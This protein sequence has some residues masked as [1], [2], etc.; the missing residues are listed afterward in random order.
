[1]SSVFLV[2]ITDLDVFVATAV[3]RFQFRTNYLVLGRKF[4]L[5][6][7]AVHSAVNPVLNRMTFNVVN[8]PISELGYDN[9]RLFLEHWDSC[10]WIS[11]L[12]CTDISRVWY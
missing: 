1:M 10:G 8:F 2:I 11:F 6:H 3:C 7:S 4:D 12:T 5:L 9:V